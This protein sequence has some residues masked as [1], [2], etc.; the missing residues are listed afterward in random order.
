MRTLKPYIEIELISEKK[1]PIILAPETAML[2]KQIKVVSVYRD[3]TLFPGDI[4]V[5]T[6]NVK[7]RVHKVD[8]KEYLFI[9]ERDVIAAL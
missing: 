5:V 6:E 3:S 4:L 8:K 2:D 9:D 1:S 7:V